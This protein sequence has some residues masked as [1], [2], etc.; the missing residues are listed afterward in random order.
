VLAQLDAIIRPYPPVSP[1][2]PALVPDGYD[3][4]VAR[5]RSV[6]QY[7][8]GGVDI[9]IENVPIE[10]LVSLTRFVRE[11]KYRQIGHLVQLYRSRGISLFDLAAGQLN[12]TQMSIATPPVVEESG[13]QFVL[14]EGSTRA[15]FCRTREFHKSN[16][17][18]CVA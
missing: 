15:T 14:V 12:A 18:S 16:V 9:S 6:G 10:K 1:S 3:L 8:K 13:G 2:I 17:W 7:S 5:L 11:Y 4:L